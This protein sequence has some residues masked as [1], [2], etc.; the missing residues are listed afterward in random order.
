ME[1]FSDLG[2]ISLMYLISL[3]WNCSSFQQV[4]GEILCLNMLLRNQVIGFTPMSHLASYQKFKTL[5]AFVPI[6]LTC[7]QERSL[8]GDRKRVRRDRSD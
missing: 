1:I 6:S 7:I 8:Q 3:T 2:I 4:W 5:G